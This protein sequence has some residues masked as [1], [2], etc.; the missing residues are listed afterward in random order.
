MVRHPHGIRLTAAGEV[1]ARY[2]ETNYARYQEMRRTIED[3][4]GE[5]LRTIRVGTAEGVIPEQI[6]LTVKHFFDLYPLTTVEISVAGSTRVVDMLR[7]DE[8]DIA[9]V[10]N[11]KPETPQLIEAEFSEPYYAVVSPDHPLVGNDRVNLAQLKPYPILLNDDTYSTTALV[12]EV[13]KEQNVEL[14]PS[15]TINS[16]EGIRALAKAGVGV[17]FL[18]ACTVRAELRLKELVC[19]RLVG[20]AFENSKLMILSNSLYRPTKPAIQFIKELIRQLNSRY[21]PT[22]SN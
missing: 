20:A 19:I 14:S 6:P 18:P 11:I 2:L 4:N 22:V 10:F 12:K 16:I 5:D 21:S 8:C 7:N 13:M 9:V 15:V 1:F 3:M 17:G